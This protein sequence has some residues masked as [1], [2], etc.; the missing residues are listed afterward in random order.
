MTVVSRERFNWFCLVS[1]DSLSRI[2]YCG[3]VTPL[4]TGNYRFIFPAHVFAWFR[5]ISPVIYS[6]AVSGYAY[7]KRLSV[8]F[9]RAG[10]FAG[11]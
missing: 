9:R 1:G 4:P 8:L 7:Q 10:Q 3:S 11:L 6:H 2:G 5:S